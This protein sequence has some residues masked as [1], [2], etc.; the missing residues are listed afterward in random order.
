MNRVKRA[1]ISIVRQPIRSFILFT[2]FILLGSTTVGA[3]S[4]HRAIEVTAVN[5]KRQ[6]PAIATIIQDN[7]ALFE[8]IEFH[9]RWPSYESTFLTAEIIESIGNL[10]YVRA[11]DYA[12][13]SQ[14]FYSRELV[15]PHDLALYASL[16]I[17]D[18]FIEQMLDR[19]SLG[20]D[21]FEH[22]RLKGIHN[23]IVVDIEEGAIELVSGRV[24]TEEEIQLASAVT[25]ISQ[26]F[27]DA[28]HLDVGST[29]TL[30]QNLYN[31]EAFTGEMSDI[32][33]DDNLILSEIVALEVIGIFT[34]LAIM[35]EDADDTDLM[36]HLDFNH[37]LYVP[38][39]IAKTPTL[40]W[41]DYLQEN[42]PEQLD[43]FGLFQYEHVIFLLYD[44]LALD[45]FNNAASALLPEFWL[46][47]DLTR[48]FHDITMSMNTLRAVAHLTLIGA[49][50]ASILVLGIVITLFLRDRKQEIGIYLALGE[51]KK[52]II[53]QMFIELL[54]ILSMSMLVALFI[55]NTMA[56]HLS[57]TMLR[58]E[59]IANMTPR[60]MGMMT[61]INDFNQMGFSFWMTH[62]EMLDVYTVV[63][64]GSV[65]ITFIITTLLIVLIATIFPIM[66]LSKLN[67]K[68]ILEKAS[69]G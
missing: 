36:N 20:M 28:N 48:A 61:S 50:I 8:Y 64:D 33:Q 43:E 55:G 9:D 46:M 60:D 41:L 47:N 17:E 37:L 52:N 23:P 40:L 12:L 5:L 18:V 59:M 34:P 54:V 6:T 4:V 32:F 49:S 62:E 69:I 30:E 14:E 7:D 67:L 24:F 45:Q 16:G 31:W 10:P 25:L 26:A 56:N 1:K 22:F 13:I 57:F 38:M 66:Y 27:A 51:K 11:F 15:L 35:D 58:N 39:G 29:L 68:N 3:I 21:G 63:L 2:L 19:F 53:S 65:V 42:A 44:P